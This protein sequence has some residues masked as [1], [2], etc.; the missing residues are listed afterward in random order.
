MGV[1]K[2]MKNVKKRKKVKCTE[3][4]FKLKFWYKNTYIYLDFLKYFFIKVSSIHWQSWGS[5]ILHLCITFF[6]N[7]D[8]FSALILNISSI[9]VNFCYLE[10]QILIAGVRE[11][12]IIVLLGFLG[13]LSYK[14]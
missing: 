1:K 6:F 14:F 3:K 10:E 13:I 9:K 8:V 2:K 7:F 12:S 5:C 11:I 4:P